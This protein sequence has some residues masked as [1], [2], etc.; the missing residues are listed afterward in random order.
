MN[1]GKIYEE[2]YSKYYAKIEFLIKKFLKNRRSQKRVFENSIN[3]VTHYLSANFKNKHNLYNN[4][5]LENSNRIFNNR[6]SIYFADATAEIL[7]NEIKS[8][9]DKIKIAELPANYNYEKFIKEIALIEAAKEI[10][11]LLSVNLRLLKMF[12]EG[13]KF[14]EFEIREQGNLSLEDYPI[15]KKLHRELYPEYYAPKLEKEEGEFSIARATE[16]NYLGQPTND[17]ANE[18][19]EYFIQYY[20]PEDKSSIKFI[21]ILHYLKNDANKDLYIFKVKQAEFKKI[22]Q[23]KIGIE[24]KKFAKSERYFEAEKPILNSLERSFKKDKG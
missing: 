21:N 12:Y 11:R 16:N 5:D 10:S 13:N 4:N 24:I 9:F 19:F 20:R 1:Y 6:Y 7:E 3:E 17:A 8:E 15:F 22:I 18:L 23:A 2:Q 14:E